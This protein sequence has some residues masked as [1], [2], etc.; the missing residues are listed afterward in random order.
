MAGDVGFIKIG[1]VGRRNLADHNLRIKWVKE[2]TQPHRELSHMNRSS[3]PRKLATLGLRIAARYGTLRKA[4]N[5]WLD[6]PITEGFFLEGTITLLI[7]LCTLL[8]DEFVVPGI[9]IAFLYMLFALLKTVA[10]RLE[11]LICALEAAI[12][13]HG[14]RNNLSPGNPAAPAF[15]SSEKS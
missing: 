9:L 7:G 12:E 5:E 1:W 8:P 3:P 15:D 4:I 6:K 11:M 14:S 13:A 10:V 2:T